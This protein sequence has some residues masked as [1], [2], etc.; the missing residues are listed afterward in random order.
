MS[1]NNLNNKK[2]IKANYPKPRISVDD[3]WRNMDNLLGPAITPSPNLPSA[4][5]GIKSVLV[6]NLK[7]AIF[8]I[9]SLSVLSVGIVFWLLRSNKNSKV[10]IESEISPI[11]KYVDTL[12]KVSEIELPKN[13][14]EDSITHIS[15]QSL[16]LED[17]EPI[18]KNGGTNLIEQKN[19]VNT[20]NQE[21][22]DGKTY[23]RRNE[24]KDFITVMKGDEKFNNNRLN[25]QD[26][27]N[28]FVPK[29]VKEKPGF[30]QP[31][32]YDSKQKVL[33]NNYTSEKDN[34]AGTKSTFPSPE[35]PLISKK[36]LSDN[37]KEKTTIRKGNDNPVESYNL[38][39]QGTDLTTTEADNVENP[40]NSTTKLSIV[41]TKAKTKKNMSLDTENSENKRI[42]EQAMG[43]KKAN[44]AIVEEDKKIQQIYSIN[45]NGIPMVFHT[46][47]SSNLNSLQFVRLKGNEKKKNLLPQKI[48][49]ADYNFGLQFNSPAFFQGFLSYLSTQSDETETFKFFIPEMWISRKIGL[50]NKHSVILSLNFNQQYFA[51]NSIIHQ[52]NVT[53][54][55]NLVHRLLKLQGISTTLKYH[56]NV[57]S[58]WSYDIGLS[59]MKDKKASLKKERFYTLSN[60]TNIPFVDNIIEIDEASEEWQYIKKEFWASRFELNYKIKQFDIGIMLNIPIENLSTIADFK[61]KPINTHLFLKWQILKK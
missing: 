22:N 57:N 27:E 10:Q 41:S 13:I 43:T 20:K 4:G 16:N 34:P 48:N 17:S 42:V 56:R 7:T 45:R 44:F 29:S 37:L 14:G 26:E 3:A 31:N 50:Q 61:N 19:E 18:S 39:K 33:Q 23:I 32:Y 36:Q 28:K 46:N 24:N 52:T 49:W 30:V 11:Q 8:L 1:E 12:D 6:S 54:D 2:E 47:L 53:M 51:G 40:V 9:T 15:P 25:L 58:K 38:K 60:N 5:T 59:Y 35:N 55:T 21:E